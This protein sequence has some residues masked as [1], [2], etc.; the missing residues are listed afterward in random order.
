MRVL[1]SLMGPGGGVLADT[2]QGSTRRALAQIPHDV[3]HLLAADPDDDEVAKVRDLCEAMGARFSVEPVTADALL[4]AFETVVAA[5]ADA[6]ADAASA[7][8]P[9]QVD[10]QVNA[11][12]HANLL[13]AAGLLACLHEGVPAHFVHEAGHEAL[14]VLTRHP[15]KQMLGEDEQ[16]AL[17]GFPDEGIRLDRVSQHDTAALNGLKDRG[18]I[19]RD[20]DR[21]VLTGRGQAY[22]IHIRRG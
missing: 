15:L 20:G 11:G 12:R 4:D 16:E 7:D 3:L 21:L 17:S 13:S 9:V 14:G 22:R 8:E 5:I 18:L 10:V 19:R 2:D 6:R 1:V